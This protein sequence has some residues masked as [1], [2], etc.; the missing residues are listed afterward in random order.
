M[1]SNIRGFLTAGAVSFISSSIDYLNVT[2]RKVRYIG[3]IMCHLI[4]T[5][6]IRCYTSIS[7]SIF[8]VKLQLIAK[9][10][11]SIQIVPS[12]SNIYIYMQ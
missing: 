1:F 4:V 6:Q 10:M 12:I 2:Y 3:T 7:V 5:F 8:M 11:Q 9:K